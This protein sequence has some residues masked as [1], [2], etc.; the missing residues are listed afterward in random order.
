[1][2]SEFGLGK[3]NDDVKTWEK[4]LGITCPLLA[5][6]TDGFFTQSASDSFGVFIC[7]QLDKQFSGLSFG[8]P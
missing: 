7:C 2:I 3:V 8:T 6:S 1:M 4:I 5:E